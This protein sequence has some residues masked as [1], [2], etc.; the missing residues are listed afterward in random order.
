MAKVFDIIN[1]AA[2]SGTWKALF[3]EGDFVATPTLV[4]VYYAFGNLGPV[5]LNQEV[6]KRPR[7]RYECGAKVL[8]TNIIQEQKVMMEAQHLTFPKETLDVLLRAQD[9][10]AYGQDALSAAVV[11]PLA[12]DTTAAVIGRFYQLYNSGKPIFKITALTLTVSATPL[13]DGTDYVLE[14]ATGMVRI[15]T[16][17]TAEVVVTATASAYDDAPMTLHQTDFRKGKLRFLYF[18]AKETNGVPCEPEIIIEGVGEVVFEE[19]FTIGSEDDAQP[20]VGYEFTD[21]PVIYDLR[22]L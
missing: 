4:P 14:K 10:A 7:Y 21:E 11:D 1:D 5:S 3:A 20:N 16:A 22:T 8:D 2:L 18:P 15:L 17:Q 12:F 19:G 9:G 6:T 13:V